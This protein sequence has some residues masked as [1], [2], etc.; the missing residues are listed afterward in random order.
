MIYIRHMAKT[1]IYLLCACAGDTE[2]DAPVPAALACDL[3]PPHD[4]RLIILLCSCAGDPELDAPIPAALA[5]DLL[6]PHGKSTY[7]FTMRMRR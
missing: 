5:R 6:Q 2:L 1:L 4:K 3:H 7:L